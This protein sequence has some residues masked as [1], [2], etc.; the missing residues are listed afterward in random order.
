MSSTF[1]T[2]LNGI[3]TTGLETAAKVATHNVNSRQGQDLEMQD[4]M[5]LMV[6]SLK[7]QTI[8]NQMELSDM[9]NQM[10]QMSVM[11][12]ITN[13]NELITQS[14]N[15]SYAASLVGK[16]VTVAQRVGTQVNHIKGTVP[17]TG[18]VNGQQAVFI[19][20]QSYWMSDIMAVGRL[21]G[22]EKADS[23]ENGGMESGGGEY[24]G[25]G[26]FDGSFQVTDGEPEGT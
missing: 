14:T 1:M 17:G 20:D 6:E 7:N 25:G 9:M 11:T 23:V 3:Y 19:G 21:P 16:E 24:S 13:I 12:A 18:V 15:L 22:E 26:G 10:V 5:T 2:D 4:F 8:D